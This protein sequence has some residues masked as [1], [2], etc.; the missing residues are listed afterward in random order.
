LFALIAIPLIALL[1]TII[2]TLFKWKFD[3]R[4]VTASGVLLWIVGFFMTL[5]GLSKIGNLFDEKAKVEQRQALYNTASDT[6]YVGYDKPDENFNMTWKFGQLQVNGA[7]FIYSDIDFDIKPSPSD[8]AYF[9]FKK[10]AYGSTIENAKAEANG[11]EY[12]VLQNDTLLTL[13]PIFKVNNPKQYRGQKIVAT[14]MLP[15]GKSVYLKKN[16]E[17]I[18][19]D[20]DNTTETYDDD[21]LGKTWTMTPNGLSNREAE[22]EKLNKKSK[23]NKDE[24]EDKNKTTNIKINGEN[25]RIENDDNKEKTLLIVNDDTIKISTK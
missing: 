6:L 23:K 5:L 12:T 2:K 13:N 14:L 4:I 17:H 19:N 20:I 22:L 10:S 1:I 11:I 8:S 25:I 15:V 24:K 7:E 9:V 21:M 3:N 18:A 16:L